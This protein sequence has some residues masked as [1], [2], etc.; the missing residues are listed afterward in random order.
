MKKLN[1][2]QQEVVNHTEGNAI[3]CAVAGSG[4]T[5]TVECWVRKRVDEGCS[6]KR[7]LCTTFTKNAALEMQ[8]RIGIPQVDV[9]TLHSLGY[10]I[11]RDGSP[12]AEYKVDGNKM[13]YVLKDILGW[14]KKEAVE[15]S[16]VFGMEWEDADITDLE[17]YISNCKG[18][19]VKP[20]DASHPDH[21]YVEVYRKYERCRHLLGLLTFDDMMSGAVWYLQEDPHARGK[22]QGMFDHVI[23]DEFQDSNAAQYELMKILAEKAKVLLVVGDDDQCQPPDTEVETADGIV[24]LGS[25]EVGDMVRVFQ[26]HNG[27]VGGHR[28]V[29]RTKRRSYYGDL[30]T[31]LAGHCSTRAT[32]DHKIPVRWADKKTE[33]WACYLMKKGDDYRVGWCQMFNMDGA[34]HLGQRARLE[35]AD[36]AWILSVYDNKGDAALQEQKIS[37]Q[38]RIPTACFK[39]QTKHVLGQVRLADLFRYV[40]KISTVDVLFDDFELQEHCPLWPF[41]PSSKSKESKWGRAGGRHGSKTFRAYAANIIPGMMQV[42]L[43]GNGWTTVHK[44]FCEEYSGEVVSLEVAEHHNYVADGI[45]VDNCIYEWRGSVPEYT[46]TFEER[47][48]ARVFRM[49]HNYRCTPQILEIANQVITGNE[50]DRITKTNVATRPDNNPVEYVSCESMDAEAETVVERIRAYHEDG[51][52]WKDMAILY[53]TNA[54]SRAFEEVCIREK[55]PH[56]VV[57][58]TEFYKRK[59]VADILAYL[60][61]AVDE[62]DVESAKRAINRPWRF[63]GKKTIDKMESAGNFM[64]VA[65]DVRMYDLGIWSKQERAVEEFVSLVQ[66][67]RDDIEPND[68]EQSVLPQALAKLIEVSGYEEWIIKDEGTDTAENSKLS[69]LRELCRTAGRF[70]TAKEMLEYVDNI[71]DTKRKAKED[72]EQP[73]AVWISTLHKAK[74]L[75]WPV[76]FLAGACEMVLPHARADGFEGDGV[77]PAE[78]RRLFY[79]GVT[80]ARDHLMITSPRGALMGGKVRPLSPSRFLQEGGLL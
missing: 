53:R 23:V 11:V 70:K 1:E 66:N 55:I 33:R 39:S 34:F 61:V 74:G 60:R 16:G 24:E 28:R 30:Y 65:S 71:L 8:E 76:V 19:L 68:A 35:E 38:Y 20:E 52:D 10:K 48:N 73:D 56:V 78:E 18:S 63:I 79:V 27:K 43:S 77:G 57:G 45:V 51:V 4:K 26:S 13:H 67:L 46:L 9:R 41:P 12:E 7:I 75:E 62:N 36:A 17:Q 47:F 54:Q 32:S 49:E 72:D 31:I 25:L 3:V 42:H 15:N 58:G 6:A 22:W 29:V 44:K 5:H 64:Q 14:C 69:N 80:R 50:P 59:E 40:R 21:R 2:T 37:L